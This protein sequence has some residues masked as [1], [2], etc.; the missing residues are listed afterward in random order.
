MAIAIVADDH[1]AALYCTTSDHAF[2]PIFRSRREAEDFLAWL[3][4]GRQDDERV[5]RLEARRLPL[6][7]GSDPREWDTPSLELLV[8]YFREDWGL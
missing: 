7:N 1:A 6:G 2:G 4:Y 3:E 8:T 5:Q